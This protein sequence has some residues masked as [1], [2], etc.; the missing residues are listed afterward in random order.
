MREAIYKNVITCIVLCFA[1]LAA[2][3]QQPSTPQSSGPR[4]LVVDKDS[5]QESGGFVATKDGAAGTYNGNVRH[6][7][8]EQIKSLNQACPSVTIT[9]AADSADFIVVWDTKTWAQTSWSGHQNEYVV[10]NKHGDVIFTGASHKISNAAKDIC[11]AV[12]SPNT[13]D[14]SPK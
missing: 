6:I 14:K 7:S 5:W 11:K 13:K 1:I 10:Y 12:T 9:A 4:I 2:A 8:T 3:Q